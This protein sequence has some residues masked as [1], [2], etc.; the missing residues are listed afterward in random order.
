MTRALENGQDTDR[1]VS[2]K[3]PTVTPVRPVKRLVER[4]AFAVAFVVIGFCIFFAAKIVWNFF[5]PTVN[6]V[7]R[8]ASPMGEWIAETDYVQYWLAVSPVY[9]TVTL[10]PGPNHASDGREVFRMEAST[11]VDIDTV[12]WQD[13]HSLTITVRGTEN[14]V[15][16]RQSDFAGVSIHYSFAK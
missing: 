14:D 3:E 7:S 1:S 10:K 13:Q 2:G 6:V 4:T 5:I 12:T 15:V 11:N 9:E 8:T 16:S